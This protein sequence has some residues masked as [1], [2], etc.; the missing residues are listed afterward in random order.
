MIIKNL[1]LA[2]LAFSSSTL[3]AANHMV[4]MGGSGDPDGPKTIFDSTAEMLGKNLQASNQWKYQ[5]AF[6]GGHSETETIIATNFSRPTAPTTPFNEQTYKK[7]IADYKAKIMSGEIASGD[8]LVIVIDT[9][10]AEKSDKSLTHQIAVNSAKKTPNRGI[11]DF[12]NLSGSDTVSLDDLQEIVKLTNQKGIKLGIIDMSCHSGNTQ[13]LKQNAPNTCIVTSTGPQHYGFAGA[14]TFNGQLW[15]SF[16]PGVNLEQAFLEARL[17]ARDNG[18]PMIS[19]PAGTEIDSEVYKAITPYMYYKS[20]ISDKLTNYIKTNSS[21]QLICQ[22]ENQFNE[23]IAK[24]NALEAAANG[25]KNGYSGQELKRLISQYKAQQDEMIKTLNQ[26]G[27]SLADTVETFIEKKSG[28]DSNP[29]QLSWKLIATSDPDGTIKY[30]QEQSKKTKNAK[31]KADYAAIIEKWN[32]VKLKKAEILR[33]YPSMSK[34]DETSKKLIAQM[35]DNY[36]AVF[37]I[38]LQEKKFY[39][40]LYRKK[41]NGNSND[42][43]AQIV[44]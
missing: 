11:T 9:H 7:M 27:G 31:E 28:P 15:N 38:T 8:Q 12:N 16:K 10:G 42:A 35:E 23:L 29:L 1:T 39:N 4:L 25:T 24:I 13:A 18:Y 26:M 33:K 36:Q 3:F 19:T 5:V 32:Q 2:V 44:F 37:S 21:D 14:G 6:N 30:F 20:P 43:C 17:N 22:R 34:L 41:Q 40:E